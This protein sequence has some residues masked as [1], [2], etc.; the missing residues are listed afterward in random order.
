[1]MKLQFYSPRWGS[2]NVA[3]DAFFSKV[4]TSGYDGVE[5]GIGNAVD[6]RELD[7]VWNLAEKYRIRMIAQCYDTGEADFSKH[8]DLYGKWFEK[9]KP[10]PCVKINSQTGRDIFSLEQHKV[11]VDLATQAE[12]DIGVE[13]LHETHRNKMLFAAHIAKDYLRKFPGM[14][15]TL[16]ISHWVCVGESF[17]ED[18]QEA[19]ALAITRTEHLHARVGYPE[20]PQVPDPRVDPWKYALAMHLSWWD[21]LIERKKSEDEVLTITTEFGPYPYMV[22]AP[23]TGKPLTDQWEVNCYMMDILRN[24]YS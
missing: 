8:L 13:V 9:I 24:R 12:Q 17:L 15:L 18:Q 19:V 2:E 23:Q 4:K 5:F 3:W 1:M 21:Q 11:I 22:H 6:E 14:K 10:Y 16:D 7:L 20:G